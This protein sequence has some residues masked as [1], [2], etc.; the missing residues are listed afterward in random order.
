MILNTEQVLHA[1]LAL[2]N[3]DRLNLAEALW[4][5]VPPTDRPGLL[6]E[7]HD[8]LR[9]RSAEIASGA[10]IPIP[11]EEVERRLDAGEKAGG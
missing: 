10:V 1:A 6:P 5:S 2:P 7:W 8:V 11:W 9:Q 3:E 4:E